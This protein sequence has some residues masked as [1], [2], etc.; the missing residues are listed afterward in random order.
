MPRPEKHVFVCLN[1]RPPGHP[2][3]SCTE[4]SAE[5]LL[6]EFGR[7]MEARQAYGKIKITRTSCLGP[8]ELGPN[9]LV[10]PD[11]IMYV[12]VQAG[13]VEEIFDRHLLGNR[14]VS[15][16]QAPVDIWE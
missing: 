6:T 13:D 4:R 5:G 2:K 11:G 15:R 9:V 16:L 10:Y 7:L 14:P 8:C 3:G 12:G 1:A